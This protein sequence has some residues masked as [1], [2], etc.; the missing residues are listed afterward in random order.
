MVGALSYEGHGPLEGV[1]EVWKRHW[2]FHLWVCLDTHQPLCYLCDGAFISMGLRIVGSRKDSQSQ[3]NTHIFLILEALSMHFVSPN[4][5]LQTILA[6][7][8]LRLIDS[9]IERTLSS[10]ICDPFLGHVIYGIAPKQIAKP[11]LLWHLSKPVQLLNVLQLLAIRGDS[12]M[13]CE[14]FLI[15]Q[16]CNGQLIEEVHDFV[17]DGLVVLGETWITDCL[18]SSRKLNMPVIMRVSWLPLRRW[19]HWGN[20]SL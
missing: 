19:M 14:V 9:K 13:H 7:K 4:D 15:N 3:R 8:I 18:H 11:S 17:I 16:C 6:E 5:H 2:M 20:L 12:S 10:V 1:Y